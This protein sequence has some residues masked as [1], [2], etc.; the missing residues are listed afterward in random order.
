[1]P[2]PKAQPSSPRIPLYAQAKRR[3]LEKL[4]AKAWRPG[5]RLPVEPELAASLGVSVGTLRRAVSELVDEGIL[6]RIQGSGTYVES[7]GEG[8]YWNRFQPFQTRDSRPLFL[9]ERI[10]VYCETIPA[11]AMIAGKLSIQKGSPVFHVMRLMWEAKF[12]VGTDEL[13]LRPEYFPGFT[14]EFFKAKLDPHESLYAFYE[15]E[16]GLEIVGTSNF[17]SCEL[18]EGDCFKDLEVPQLAGAPLCCFTRVSRT[19][20]HT[21]V[22][23]RIMHCDFRK[24]QLSFDL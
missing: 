7:Y 18:N 13:F 21:P 2:S 9:K 16:F 17:V 4:K 8:S 20:G 12:F 1:M 3:M 14:L 11:S 24:L 10:P 15:R 19:Y 22:E 23:V 5:D 6:R